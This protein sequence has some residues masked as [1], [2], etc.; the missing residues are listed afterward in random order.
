MD[1]ASSSETSLPLLRHA[2]A[3]IAYRGGKAIR[4]VPDGFA[5]FSA[6]K[7][8][9]TPGEILAHIADLFDWATSMTKGKPAWNSGASLPWEEGVKRFFGSI[10]AFD[11]A[12]ASAEPST[13]PAD[14]LFQG[15]LADALTHV[16]QISLLRRLAGGPVRAENYVKADIAAGRV[17]PDQIPPRMEFD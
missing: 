4:G 5:D 11:D 1:D 14:K 6:G 16:G 12:L 13:I 3:T 9:R 17:G 7:G 15:P 8:M 10:K 2:V